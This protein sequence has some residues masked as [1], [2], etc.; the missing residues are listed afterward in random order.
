MLPHSHPNAF[1]RDIRAPFPGFG[2]LNPIDAARLNFHTIQF[3]MRISRIRG[4]GRTS[5]LI[6]TELVNPQVRL[7]Y[8]DA[9]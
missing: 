7:T 6:V 2:P 3:V 5:I 1:R 4:I 9:S 8:D